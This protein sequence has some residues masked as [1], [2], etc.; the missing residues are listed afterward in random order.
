M[1]LPEHLATASFTT[2]TARQAGLGR[3]RLRGAD[4]ERPFRGVRTPTSIDLDLREL[5][6]ALSSRVPPSAFICGL[7]AAKLYEMPLP[8]RLETSIDVHV[9]VP[10]PAT[11]PVGR[12]IRGHSYRVV[13]REIAMVDG[14]RVSTPERAWCELSV[15]LS[16]D[17]LIAAGDHIIHKKHGV[18]NYPDLADQVDR[19]PARRAKAIRLEALREIDDGAESAQETRLRLVLARAGIDGLVTQRWITTSRGHRY[20]A[21]IAV[22]DRKTV[23]EYQSSFHDSDSRRRDDMTRRSRLEADR[24]TVIEINADDL[25]DPLELVARVR[26]LLGPRVASS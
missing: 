22:P 23:I 14:L 5:C 25:R 12:G 26:R 7:T 13:D 19:F 24:W 10:A 20:R 9:A 11:A 21:D 16:L 17:E 15:L 2:R 1:P 6:L 18:S 8:W 3:G 4:L